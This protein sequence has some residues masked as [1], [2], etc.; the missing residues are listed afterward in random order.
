MNPGA[1]GCTRESKTD[2]QSGGLG[3]PIRIGDGFGHYLSESLFFADADVTKDWPISFEPRTAATDHGGR[4]LSESRIPVTP[5]WFDRVNS[6]ARITIASDPQLWHTKTVCI[7]IP[8]EKTYTIFVGSDNR[9]NLKIDGVDYGMCTGDFCFVDGRFISQTLKSGK[10]LVEMKYYDYGGW[11][12]LW[13]EIYDQPI[14]SVRAATRES[15]LSV[16]FSTKS[17][18]GQTWDFS[19]EVCPEGYAY[20]VCAGDKK[21]TKL[22]RSACL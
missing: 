1:D 14:E 17:L 11:G 20:D 22:E 21:C 13:Y 4:A 8:R 19:G 18:V 12:A 2:P 3:R 16:L 5:F 6:P 9:W 7:D 10:H 15:D